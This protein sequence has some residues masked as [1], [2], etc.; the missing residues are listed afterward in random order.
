MQRKFTVRTQPLAEVEI[1]WPN[2]L[3]MENQKDPLPFDEIMR[4][5]LIVK[6]TKAKKKS[7]PAKAKA[8]KKK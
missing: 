1:W 3:Y 6:P 5:A 8:A 2:I 4:R 7:R